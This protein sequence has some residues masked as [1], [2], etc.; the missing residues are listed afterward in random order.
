MLLDSAPYE[1]DDLIASYSK[2]YDGIILSDDK[3]LGCLVRKGVTQH[4]PCDAKEGNISPLLDVASIKK[5]WGVEPHKVS[6]VLSL[7]GDGIDEVVGLK[8]VGLVTAK[9]LLAKHGTVERFALAAA[10]GKGTQW[11]NRAGAMS[12]I[13]S[14]T[15]MTR[16]VDA[17]VPKLFP[18]LT[19]WPQKTI[20]LLQE[21][22]AFSTAKALARRNGVTLRSNS[23]QSKGSRQLFGGRKT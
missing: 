8:G 3:D 15:A 13:I 4:R 1:A 9:Q 14:M 7:S 22:E 5:R 18:R 11:M 12:A 16:L 17:P 2:Q 21:L 10:D 23:R 6:D 20:D 19:N